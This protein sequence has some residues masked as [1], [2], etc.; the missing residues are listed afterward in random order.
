VTGERF[1]ADP[2]QL[3]LVV[4]VSAGIDVVAD[5][6][7]YGPQATFSLAAVGS[8]MAA[9]ATLILSAALLA[10][11]CR[12]RDLVL[13][14]PIIVLASFVPVQVANAAINVLPRNV[15]LP[16]GASEA[17]HNAVLVW[18]FV[19][20]VRCAWV[21][22]PVEPARAWRS[23]VGG[24]L[25]ALPLVIPAGILPSD[26][27]WVADESDADSAMNPASEPVL[28]L[29]R[30]LQDDALAALE[31]HVQGS[32]DL[33]FIGF[34]PDGAGATWSERIAAARNVLEGHWGA[35]GHT[36][37]YVNDVT[38]LGEAPMASVSNLREALAEIAA[39]ADPDE[40]VLML[41]LAGRNNADGTMTVSLP[42]LDLVQLSGAGL[43]SLLDEAGFAWR[44]V[45][46]STCVPGPFIEALTDDRTMLIANAAPDTDVAECA[47]RGEPVAFGDA[48]FNQAL[49]RT[50]SLAAAFES[51]RRALAH[52]EGVGAAHPVPLMHLGAEVARK[53]E[54]VRGRSTSGV[55]V[56]APAFRR[57]A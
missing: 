34:A 14:I 41:Y 27:W 11:W 3:V 15:T 52:G 43:R 48:F 12:Q 38:T 51:A 53:L 45:V 36:L 8:E 31:D 39:A 16:E 46:I 26:P 40:D 32:T 1:R 49:P 56:R 4:L 28:A 29:Q 47:R 55:T 50:T 42:P 5:W 20:L 30:Q 13:E 24:V 35:E 37:G 57:P 2:S 54:S 6:Y 7:R 10:W 23:F 22:I 21:A 33:Y 18:L 25:L 9:A 44:V 17:L 19:V